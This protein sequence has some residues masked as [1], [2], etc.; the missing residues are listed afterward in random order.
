MIKAVFIDFYGT[1]VHED[2]E[3]IK[4]I[5][6]RVSAQ[7]GASPA[8]IGGYWWNEFESLFAASYG[9]SFRPQRV[10]EKISLIK[11]LAHF[12]SSESMQALSEQLYEHW[13]KAPL[14]AESREFLRVCPFPVY[15]VS[16]IDSADLRLAI[17]YH[18]LCVSGIATSEAARAYKPRPEIFRYALDIA[19]IAPQEAVHIGDSLSSDVAGA[20]AAGIKAV[21][22]NRRKRPIPSGIKYAVETLTDFFN[23]DINGEDADG[24]G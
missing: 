19:A 2:G 15:I 4:S 10:L 22:L 6:E 5:T 14:F 20:E 11:T 8:Q 16:N 12:R 7:S 1:L 13:Q 21:W 3:I 17:D 9:D 24:N 18:G 23:L